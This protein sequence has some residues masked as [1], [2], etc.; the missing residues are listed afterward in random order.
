[1]KKIFLVALITIYCLLFTIIAPSA[2]ANGISLGIYPPI[3][4]INATPPAQIQAPLSVENRGDDPIN[5]KIELRPFVAS[6]QEDGLIKYVT[7]DE[8]NF[9][10]PLLFQRVRI[11][12]GINPIDSVSLSGKQQKNL[13]LAINI[14]NDSPSSDYYFSV[15]FLTAPDNSS[16]INSSQSVSGIATN[17]LLS[18]GAGNQATGLIQEFSSPVFLDKGPVPFSVRVKNTGNH[19]ITPH[20]DILIK[21]LFGQTVGKVDLVETNILAKTVRNVPSKDF[22]D[23]NQNLPSEVAAYWPEKFLLGPYKASLTLAISDQGP[24]FS[25]DVYFFALPFKAL[26]SIIAI[27]LIGGYIFIRVKK[28]L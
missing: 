4:Q 15:I 23:E 16:Q 10:D 3:F 14:P 5:L 11:Y 12:D 26:V 8:A 9:A 27:L 1:M 28:R 20:G 18:V 21:N 13:T 22:L 24:I 7:Q 19:F 6:D 25:R 17:V 2:H